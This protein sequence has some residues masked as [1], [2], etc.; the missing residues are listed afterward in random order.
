MN[1]KNSCSQQKTHSLTSRTVSLPLE[2]KTATN[3][4][5]YA[6]T[7]NTTLR[8]FCFLLLLLLVVVVVVVVVVVT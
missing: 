5:E 8:R 6:V 2:Y 4:T 1:Q 7:I 3:D